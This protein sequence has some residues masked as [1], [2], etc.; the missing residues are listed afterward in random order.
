M[1]TAHFCLD[2]FI[3]I[4]TWVLLKRDDWRRLQMALVVSCILVYVTLYG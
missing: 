4:C 3:V 2:F 1:L